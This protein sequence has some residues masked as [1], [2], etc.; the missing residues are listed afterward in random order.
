MGRRSQKHQRPASSSRPGLVAMHTACSCGWWALKRSSGIDSPMPRAS[1]SRASISRTSI[2][3]PQYTVPRTP[4][5]QGPGPATAR[6]ICA[7]LDF[8]RRKDATR[9]CDRHLARGHMLRCV[10]PAASIRGC[11]QQRPLPGH[12]RCGVVRR[13]ERHP[14]AHPTGV[15]RIGLATCR[16]S[17]ASP[18]CVSRQ[19]ISNRSGLSIARWR[20]CGGMRAPDADRRNRAK[21]GVHR[22]IPD[23]YRAGGTRAPPSL[24]RAACNPLVRITSCRGDGN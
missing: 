10:A 18:A 5:R 16:T 7:R 8:G 1:I 6:A 13:N 20:E 12:H 3:A 9:D 23:L 21:L 2:H 11:R 22:P 19:Y 14:P 4:S 15:W 17:A 24:I